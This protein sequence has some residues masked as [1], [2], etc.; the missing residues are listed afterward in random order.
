MRRSII[1]ILLCHAWITLGLPL[2][3]TPQI[4]LL[5]LSS[6]SFPSILTPSYAEPLRHKLG[7]ILHVGSLAWNGYR[8]SPGVRTSAGVI[9]GSKERLW[10]EN[11]R[12]ALQDMWASPSH[13]SFSPQ[14]ST[15]EVPHPTAQLIRLNAVEDNTSLPWSL[16]PAQPLSKGHGVDVTATAPRPRP[17]GTFLPKSTSP[18]SRSIVPFRRPNLT[19][20]LIR[21]ASRMDLAAW[22]HRF[23]PEIIGLG[24]FLLVPAPVLIVEC[25]DRLCDWCTPERF[26]ERGRG[27]VRL[28]GME[29]Q[30]S[31]L[32]AW[33]R[34]KMV[35]EQHSRRWW[36]VGRRKR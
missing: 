9:D 22:C 1:V 17:Y 23:S 34:E 11:R 2:Q 7:L 8:R 5:S 21:R 36:R 13:I 33:E 24:I 20:T 15:G 27:R 29:R 12:Q 4:P 32:A 6:I 35:E 25:V 28:T 14:S 16:L 3:S 18:A 31:A 26:P 10:M 19:E 30:L